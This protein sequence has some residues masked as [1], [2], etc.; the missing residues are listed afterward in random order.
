[1]GDGGSEMLTR[2]ASKTINKSAQKIL[3][4]CGLDYIDTFMS[5]YLYMY[6][7]KKKFKTGIYL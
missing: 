6:I 1:M 7:C 2:K 5:N 4:E 3:I